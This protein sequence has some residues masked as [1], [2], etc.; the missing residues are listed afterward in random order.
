LR[1]CGTGGGER[2]DG[3]C[4]ADHRRLPFHRQFAC[5]GFLAPDL[6]SLNEAPLPTF[7]VIV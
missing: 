3:Q 7:P 4:E 2:Q 1:V 5:T 6:P